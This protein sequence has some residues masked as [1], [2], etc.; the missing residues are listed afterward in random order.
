MKKLV[1]RH[2]AIF[3]LASVVVLGA[4]GTAIWTSVLYTRE[5]ALLSIQRDL[6]AQREVALEAQQDQRIRAET[7]AEYARNQT[8]IAEQRLV[9]V[10]QEAEAKKESLKFL[11][12]IFAEVRSPDGRSGK[13]TALELL[14]RGIARLVADKDKSPFVRITL[15]QAVGRAA[16]NAGLFN[17]AST[18]LEEGLKLVREHSPGKSMHATLTADLGILRRLQGRTQEALALLREGADVY[19]E[20]EGDTSENAISARVNLAQIYRD[21]G[22][23]RLAIASA[24]DLI[25]LTPISPQK[26]ERRLNLHTIIAM[27]H[28][29]LREYDEARRYLDSGL[30]EFGAGD[31]TLGFASTLNTYGVI[32]LGQGQLA[33]ARARFKE[34]LDVRL[35]FLDADHDLI[36]E[37]YNNLGAVEYEVDDFALASVYLE[38]SWAIHVKRFGTNSTKVALAESNRAGILVK[39]GDYEAAEALAQHA[40]EV[41]RAAYGNL[42]IHVADTLVILGDVAVRRGKLEAAEAHLA[43]AVQ[44]FD[45]KHGR[46]HPNTIEAR[47]RLA[48]CSVAGKRWEAAR[49]RVDEALTDARGTQGMPVKQLAEIETLA[50]LISSSA[51]GPQAQTDSRAPEM[52]PK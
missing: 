26:R 2:Q 3:V 8:Q 29:D 48:Q 40:L 10:G 17:D 47:F 7:A 41:R 42:H 13:L 27:S 32:L 36:A 16:T 22:E 49:S 24:K 37:S 6:V 12:D 19:A 43:E 15:L 46:L 51:N 30:A 38:K 14:K 9:V 34:A 52:I 39:L 5:S 21:S 23:P 18:L 20:A 45:K 28:N 4:I 44:I 25:A 11:V 31:P 33:A 50:A 1:A 35:Q